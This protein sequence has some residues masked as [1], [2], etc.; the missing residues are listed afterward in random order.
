MKF[1]LIAL[2]AAV[3]A[4]ASELELRILATIG[5]VVITTFDLQ[6]RTNTEIRMLPTDLSVQERN[7]AIARLH[8]QA[9]D[10]AIDHELIYQ[11]FVNLKGKV[12]P[13][14]LQ[15]RIDR[16]ILQQAGGDE[17][18]F[19]DMLH[20]ENITYK[21][22]KDQV[23]K[24]LAV[25]MLTYDRTR[26]NIFVSN[27]E[28]EDYFLKNIDKYAAPKRERVQVIMLKG[29]GKFA[30]KLQA[31]VGEIRYKLQQGESFK[32][33]AMR[34][35]EGANSENGGDIGWQTSM[36]PKL[37]EVVDS[38]QP[39]ELY[40][41]MLMIGENAYIVRLMD[42]EGGDTPLLTDEIQAGI[43]AALEAEIA[44]ERYREY[45]KTLYLKYPV[46]RF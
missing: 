18:R 14:Y 46:R 44:A 45:V 19:K 37:Q 11:D 41:G 29:D 4:S 42:R 43:R 9:L 6:Q 7:L 30:G 8:G 3:V 23:H 28:V 22:F 34:Y 24:N 35:S 13:A 21:E 40:D 26:R 5:D 25:E 39:G 1:V 36:A 20:R 33:L 38:L 17:T 15:E 31:T 32:E 16:I 27:N 2:L 12:P 10:Q